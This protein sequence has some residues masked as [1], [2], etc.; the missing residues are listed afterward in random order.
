LFKYFGRFCLIF[1]ALVKTFI[2]LF[3]PP[4][5]RFPKP[6]FTLPEPNPFFCRFLPFFTFPH[7]PL[8]LHEIE[9]S[10]KPKLWLNKKPPQILRRFLQKSLLAESIPVLRYQRPAPEAI[11]ANQL[12]ISSI[13]LISLEGLISRFLLKLRMFLMTFSDGSA[14]SAKGIFCSSAV[15]FTVRSRPGVKVSVI[16]NKK[17]VF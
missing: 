16:G 7:H 11:R 10:P 8:W 4:Q 17:I 5:S 15:G 9:E 12:L 2:N 3:R 14:K 6:K 1:K 13:S